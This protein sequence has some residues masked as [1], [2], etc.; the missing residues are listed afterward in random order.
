MWC[1]NWYRHPRAASLCV[2][3]IPSVKIGLDWIIFRWSIDSHRLAYLLSS[4]ILD[5]C[6][7]ISLWVLP[8]VPYQSVRL[9]LS[10][11]LREEKVLPV[12]YIHST[13]FLQDV[14]QQW[15]NVCCK[16]Y[17]MLE[18]ITNSEY[19]WQWV[20]EW[21]EV[22]WLSVLHNSLMVVLFSSLSVLSPNTPSIGHHLDPSPR[23][24]SDG[25]ELL[26]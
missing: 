3:S 6:Y 26:E 21:L 13:L 14:C 20:V 5:K 22:Q 4:S 19:D 10:H 9:F 2:G 23:S 12:F 24:R 15:L 7:P 17:Q 18:Y 25:V 8:L 11:Q 1:P 16:W